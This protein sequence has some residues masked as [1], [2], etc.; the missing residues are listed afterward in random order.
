MLFVNAADSKVDPPNY[1]FSLDSLE[2]FKPGSTKASITAKYGKGEVLNDGDIT[3]VKYYVSQI[4]YKFP[5]F[6]QLKA[7]VSVGFFARLPNYFSHDLYHQSLINR[8]GKQ[9]KYHKQ[10]N[11]AVYSWSN[12]NGITRTYQGAC[13]ITCFPIYYSVEITGLEESLLK[14]MIKKI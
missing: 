1:N 3:L 2:I 8:Y 10:E 6:V 14:K 4:R 12:Q 5:V 7:G 11:H 13:T 9:T